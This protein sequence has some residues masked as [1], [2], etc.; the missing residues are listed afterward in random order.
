MS[1]NTRVPLITTAKRRDHFP[2][3]DA[4]CHAGL[5]HGSPIVLWRTVTPIIVTG[6]RVARGKLTVR[7]TPNA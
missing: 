4:T 6:S 5:Y 3:C 2:G 7:A 1:P